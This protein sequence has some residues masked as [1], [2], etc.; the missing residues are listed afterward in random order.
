MPVRSES[1]N[2]DIG[3]LLQA[4]PTKTE[5]EAL[6]L[7]L[8][9]AHHQDIQAVRTDV[10]AI[11]DR[12]STGETS[13]SALEHRAAALEGSQE[14]QMDTAMALQLHLEDLKDRSRRNN[15]RL[16][17]LPEATGTENLADTVT[18]VFHKIL[19]SPQSSLE[20]DRIHRALG[21]KPSDPDKPQD[22][23]CRIQRYTQKEDIIHRDWE[24]G[25]VDFDGAAIRILPDLSGVTVQRRAML[26]RFWISPATMDAPIA[27]D[28]H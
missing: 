16:R 26:R 12:V 7:R 17:G 14:T 4:L 1:L 25:E 18:A 6:I 2:T 15:L 27:G 9:D 19:A 28:T 23:I 24:Q 22:V 8:V 3:V 13:L 5:I 20:L 11:S 21:P 10:Q